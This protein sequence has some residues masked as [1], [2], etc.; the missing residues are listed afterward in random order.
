M[1]KI[2]IKDKR[3]YWCNIT[4]L[5]DIKIFN[6]LFIIKPRKD[7]RVLQSSGQKNVEKEDKNDTWHRVERSHGRFLR[8]FRLPENAKMGQVKV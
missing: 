6:L 3:N 8:K 1:L 4:K 2:I 7:D 5:R